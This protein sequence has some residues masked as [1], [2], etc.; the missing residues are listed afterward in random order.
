MTD[1]I[2]Q[3]A[4]DR[5]NQTHDMVILMLGPDNLVGT[6]HEVGGREVGDGKPGWTGGRRRETRVDVRSANHHRVESTSCPPGGHEVGS[7][8]LPINVIK[9]R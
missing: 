1:Q 3:S 4:T 6:G 7:L 5:L 8:S 2:R 9:Q